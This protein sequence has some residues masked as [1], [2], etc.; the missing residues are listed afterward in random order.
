MINED[1]LRS[2]EEGYTLPG[3]QTAILRELRQKPK[4]IIVL[5]D[6]PTGT[7]TV[8][9]IPVVT[10]WSEKTLERELKNSPIFFILTNSRSLQTEAANELGKLIGK[11]LK[12]ISERLHKEIAVIS[13]SDSTLRGHYPGEVNALIE[14]LGKPRAKHILAPAFFEGGRYTYNDIHYV[15]EDD[16]FIPAGE[17]PFAEDNTFGYESSNLRDWIVEKYQGEVSPKQI[18][19]IS[20]KNLR[21]ESTYSLAKV[22]AEEK[23]THIVVNA[24]SK[25]DLQIMALTCLQ[26]EGPLIYRTGASF[27]NA[28]SGIAEK[29]C[30]TKEEVLGKNETGGALVIVGSY[31]PKTTQQLEYLKDNGD[32]TLLELDV[33][34]V[35]DPVTFLQQL[36]RLTIQIDK[37]ILANKNVVLY[38]SRTIIKGNT[39]AESLEI[40]NK[41]SEGLITIVQKL[42]HRPKYIL[43]KG[44]ITSSDIATKGLAVRRAKVLGQVLKGVPVWLLDED[45]KFP[46]LPYIVFPGNVGDKKAV[47][48]LIELLK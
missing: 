6:D 46:D 16:V 37:A 31:V 15:K 18:K 23:T 19:G 24:T 17:T 44:G 8:Y 30:L 33:T 45:A 12:T 38:T 11:R 41:V 35:N 39:K 28:L 26:H 14:G 22:L 40:V 47:Y 4:S 42:S 3:H 9:N 29:P 27:V 34:T 36:N 2:I 32:V 25:S 1:I 5:D 48:E 13:R 43:A 21:E 20:V 10:E 7:Q